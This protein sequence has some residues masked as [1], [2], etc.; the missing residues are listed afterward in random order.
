MPFF[1]EKGVTGV[2]NPAFSS[3]RARIGL[4]SSPTSLDASG[5]SGMER[6]STRFDAGVGVAST[7]GGF[8]KKPRREFCLPVDFGGG[9]LGDFEDIPGVSMGDELA[10]AI[11]VVLGKEG[12]GGE[13]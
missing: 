13:L 12:G 1:S 9:F 8:E 4:T 5:V 3:I 7:G 11:E 10:F 2:L 6:A